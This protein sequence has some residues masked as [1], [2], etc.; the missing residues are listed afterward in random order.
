MNI[1][2][3][4]AGYVGL[5]TGSCLA[6]VGNQVS[7]VERDAAK[8]AGFQRGEPGFHEPGLGTLLRDNIVAG[9]LK[10]TADPS[11]GMRRA[12]VVFIAVNT[13]QNE[14]GAADI[15]DVLLAAEHVAAHLP[16][17]L[18]LVVVKSTVPPGT[19]EQVRQRLQESLERRGAQVDLVVASN[20][21]FL[22]EGTAVEDFMRPDRI[23]VGCDDTRGT[24]LLRKLYA[25]FNHNHDRFVELGITAAEFSKYAANAMLAAR[26]SMM[27]EFANLAE[28]LDV[29]IEDVRKSIGMDQRIGYQYLYPGCG[30]GGSCLPKDIAALLHLAGQRGCAVPLLQAVKQVNDHQ[31]TR[32]L[33]KIDAHF[34]KVKGLHFAVWGLAFKPDTDDMREAPSRTVLE[35]LWQ[36]GATV[37]A[38]DPVTV[39]VESWKERDDFRYCSDPYQALMDADALIVLTEWRQYRSPDFDRMLTLLKQAVIF[40]GR[41]LYDPNT[42]ASR[43]FHHYAIGRGKSTL[44]SMAGTV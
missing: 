26:I 5:V 14:E 23:I 44:G 31:R 25:P 1:T 28:F 27:N 37:A 41:N 33:R 38:S 34:P 15:G 2:V 43:G 4:G 21:E 8:F 30:Y 12:D 40:D 24:S 35:G 7:C 42:M 9:R 32:L 16:E 17:G 39:G 36:R 18:R 10:F 29:D 13:P 22:R 6:A 3:I 11:H 20:P 19:T